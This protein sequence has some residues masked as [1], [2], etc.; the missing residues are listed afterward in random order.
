[1]LSKNNDTT[2]HVKTIQKNYDS[3]L[4]IALRY[5]SVINERS[6]YKRYSLLNCRVTLLPNPKTKKYGTDMMA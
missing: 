1:M 3:I 2:I 4:Q 6:F 5:F